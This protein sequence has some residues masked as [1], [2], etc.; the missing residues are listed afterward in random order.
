MPEIIDIAFAAIENS[1]DYI[2]GAYYASVGTSVSAPRGDRGI[3][4]LALRRVS[5]GGE[6]FSG[7]LGP[8]ALVAEC[9]GQGV[10]PR[11]LYCLIR[12]GKGP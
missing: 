11:G 3:L 10:E 2:R 1:F 7:R 8:L 9:G 5:D 4:A 6:G 12:S